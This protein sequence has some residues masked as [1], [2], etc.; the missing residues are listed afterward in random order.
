MGRESKCLYGK[1]NHEMEKGYTLFL[2]RI[3][4]DHVKM[5]GHFQMKR[6]LRT[7]SFGRDLLS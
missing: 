2:E 5:T 7:C 4:W 6:E 1:I 3:K